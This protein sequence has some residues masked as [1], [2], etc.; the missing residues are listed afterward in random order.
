MHLLIL[1]ITVAQGSRVLQ[2]SLL[3]RS[4]SY[5]ELSEWNNS[6]CMG[7]SSSRPSVPPWQSDF[8]DNS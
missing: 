2:A 5:M 7:F 6:S 4:I 1:F 3:D 8:W